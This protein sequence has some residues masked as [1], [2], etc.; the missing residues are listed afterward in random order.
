MDLSKESDDIEDD[1]K[2]N[3][4]ETVKKNIF[5]PSEKQRQ[6]EQKQQLH[7][8][9]KIEQ[10]KKD[11]E[12]ALQKQKEEMK[13][14]QENMRRQQDLLL[15]KMQQQS[16]QQMNNLKNENSRLKKKKSKVDEILRKNEK[17]FNQINKVSISVQFGGRK[18]DI[19]HHVFLYKHKKGSERIYKSRKAEIAMIDKKTRSFRKKRMLKLN[20]WA[21]K[22]RINEINKLNESTI[23][24]LNQF[25]TQL[26]DEIGKY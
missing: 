15:K 11:N 4:S 7:F 10:M 23:K 24:K 2:L 22:F 20:D 16:Q 12:L 21:N 5:D 6:N 26:R 17:Q 25:T 8:Q 18:G 1:D 19:V 13:R 3:I 14:Q 9:K